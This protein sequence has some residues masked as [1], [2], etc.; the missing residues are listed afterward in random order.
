MMK[1]N[2]MTEQSAF[3]IKHGEFSFLS[4]SMHIKKDFA[5]ISLQSNYARSMIWGLQINILVDENSKLYTIILARIIPAYPFV[6]FLFCIFLL[7]CPV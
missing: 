1:N 5:R 2:A 7:F 3:S 4:K 6:Y